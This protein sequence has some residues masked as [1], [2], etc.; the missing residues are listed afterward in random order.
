M[1]QEILNIKKKGRMAES[2]DRLLKITQGCREDMH[3]PDEQ[4]ITVCVKGHY[5]DN[6]MGDNPVTNSGELTVG[7]TRNGKIEWFNL[8]GLIALARKSPFDI[9]NRMMADDLKRLLKVTK[10][11]RED[12]RKPNEQYIMAC[13]KG[14]HLD[15][16]MGDD[17]VTNRGEFT[18]E[19]ASY[20]TVKKYSPTPYIEWF[21]LA[22]LIA[23]A[24]RAEV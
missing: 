14:D 2:L 6:E 12:M 20:G 3:E 4:G 23:L 22:N 24:R 5:L 1:R 10:W 16:A 7:I 19:L 13:V 9:F 11:C 8:A 17:P 21:N 15:N 18:V